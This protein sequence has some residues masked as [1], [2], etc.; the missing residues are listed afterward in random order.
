MVY[1]VYDPFTKNHKFLIN[2]LKHNLKVFNQKLDEIHEINECEDK[3]NTYIILINHMFLIENNK[4]KKDYYNLLKKKNKILY[5]TEPLELLIEIKFY[6][7]IIKELKPLKVYTYC[8]E[9]LIKIKPLCKYINFYPINKT[10]F[11]FLDINGP[12]YNEKDLTKIVFIGKM[13]NYRNKIKELFKDDLIIIED[14]YNKEEWIE[15]IKK[16]QY[17]IN[18]HRRPNSKCFESMR[19]LPLLYNDCTIISEHVNKK[20]ESYFKESNIYFCKLEEMK[21]KFEEIKSI[22]FNEIVRN[23][24]NTEYNKYINMNIFFG[25]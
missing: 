16:Y 8:E 22:S 5:I 13:N 25:N 20:E 21:D 17:F 9:N 7:K 23:S 1:L 2:N 3:E 4:A 19:I 14:K 15:I 12:M 18:V 24:R 10:Y 11:K 6:I